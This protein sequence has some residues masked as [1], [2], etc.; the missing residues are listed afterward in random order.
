MKVTKVYANPADYA[1]TGIDI[2]LK[3]DGLAS[4]GDDKFVLFNVPIRHL[5]ETDVA[6]VL[7]L[8][9]KDIQDSIFLDKILTMHHKHQIM[10]VF[11]DRIK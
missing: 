1:A 3:I 10:K 9:A 2:E 5:D 11:A 6:H 7:G 8:D 4:V